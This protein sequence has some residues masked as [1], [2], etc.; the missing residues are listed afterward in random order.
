MSSTSPR[1][2]DAPDRHAP[3]VVEACR[4]QGRGFPN[5]IW[6]VG[7]ILCYEVWTPLMEILRRDIS[8]FMDRKLAARGAT[9][10]SS[11]AF[12]DEAVAGLNRYRGITTGRAVLRMLCR[13]GFGAPSCGL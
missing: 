5:A 6:P 2:E 12:T 4:R 8:A 1:P 7:T 13:S 10:R 3:A 9:G 11:R